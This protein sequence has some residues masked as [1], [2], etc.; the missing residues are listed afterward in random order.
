[1]ASEK[2][3][4]W[5]SSYS[6]P[7]PRTRR[8]VFCML[9][10]TSFT[11][12]EVLMLKCLHKIYKKTSYIDVRMQVTA[13][14]V[15][16]ARRSTFDIISTTNIHWAD[17]FDIISTPARHSKLVAQF[18]LRHHSTSQNVGQAISTTFQHLLDVQ[19]FSQS[20]TYSLHYYKMSSRPFR[21]QFDTSSTLKNLV[22][23]DFRHHFDITNMS[24]K[25]LQHYF[26]I[27]STSKNIQTVL[28]LT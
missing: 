8:T 1:M 21:H 3:V 20:S 28:P 19:N 23:F 10:I 5:Y 18:D 17:R 4:I 14:C 11:K 25:L 15:Q 24:S 27:W 6:S 22:K 26:H 7:I 13:K 9:D 16:F 12:Y 2:N